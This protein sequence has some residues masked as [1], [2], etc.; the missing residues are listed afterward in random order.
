MALKAHVGF[1]IPAVKNVG[2]RIVSHFSKLGYRLL[3]E[4]SNQWIFERGKKLA[5]LW[6]F[7]VRAYATRLVVRVANQDTGD[8]WVYCDWEVWT[9]MTIITGGDIGTLDVEGH[10]LESALRDV[11]QKGP[12]VVSGSPPIKI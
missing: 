9:F 6:R 10:Q 1:S 5:V 4:S 12:C 7:N 11:G 3:D 2:P 8:L